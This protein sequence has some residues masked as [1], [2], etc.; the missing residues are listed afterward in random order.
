[1]SGGPNCLGSFHS[2]TVNLNLCWREIKVANRFDFWEELRLHAAAFAEILVMTDDKSLDASICA[3]GLDERRCYVLSQM[4]QVFR[5]CR[6]HDGRQDYSLSTQGH[7]LCIRVALGADGPQRQPSEP[8][9]RTLA[10]N[11]SPTLQSMEIGRLTTIAQAVVVDVTDFD[12]K[13]FAN[14]H[15][16]PNTMVQLCEMAGPPMAENTAFPRLI[17]T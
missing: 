13:D 8:A 12:L 17:G 4:L 10:C 15:D 16:F 9:S 2:A 11:Q 3:I 5:Y 1:M 14:A 7:L 6:Q